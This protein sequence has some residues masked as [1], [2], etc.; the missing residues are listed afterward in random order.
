MNSV[1]LIGR[2]VRD[3]SLRYAGELPVVNFSLAI[4]RVKKDGAKTADFPKVIALGKTGELVDKY[5]HKGMLVGISGRL[6]TGS[7]EKDGMKIY[8][9]EVVADRVTF[10]E[11]PKEEKSGFEDITDA[12]IPF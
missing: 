11:W 3:P 4:E 8:T 10:I 1:N 6:Q 9:T 2:L 7:Y 12:D 5:L